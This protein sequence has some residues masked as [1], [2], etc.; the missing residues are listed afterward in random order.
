MRPV[1]VAMTGALV[2]VVILAL[3]GLAYLKGTELRG[4]PQPGAIETQIA[5]ALRGLAIP[6]ASRARTNP[7]PATQEAISA[8]LEHYA[9]YCTMCH[10]NDGSG[11][12]TPLG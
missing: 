9:H 2:L 8:G 5:R 11:E 3:G 6:R 1:F 10:A 12:D 7:I 4:Q